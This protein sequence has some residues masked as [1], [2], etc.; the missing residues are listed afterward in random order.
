MFLPLAQN[1]SGQKVQ[2]RFREGLGIKEALF[3]LQVA[4][5]RFYAMDLVVYPW[6]INSIKNPCGSPTL[7][8]YSKT[9][10]QCAT[11]TSNKNQRGEIK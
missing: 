2:F 11:C 10:I 5:K 8:G 6:F 4:R 3:C 9:F 1:A 7:E